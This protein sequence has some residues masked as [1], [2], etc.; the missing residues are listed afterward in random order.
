MY[1]D[2]KMTIFEFFLLMASDRLVLALFITIPILIINNNLCKMNYFEMQAI[3]RYKTY[4]KWFANKIIQLFSNTVIW[5]ILI[6]AITMLLGGF[7]GF[8]YTFYWEDSYSISNH[9]MLIDN[10]NETGYPF[11]YLVQYDLSPVICIIMQTLFLICRC[12]LYSIVLLIINFMFNKA[13]MG[14]IITIMINWLEI[15]FNNIILHPYYGFLPF[16]RM[17]MV[18]INGEP[19][20]FL[21]SCFYW[22]MLISASIIIGQLINNRMVETTILNLSRS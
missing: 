22:V 1:A 19:P 7:F 15:N 21:L 9:L 17:I 18:T 12:F 8:K 3:I 6:L 20:N 4:G 16:E 10:I 14:L 5:I 2:T 11:Y 13:T